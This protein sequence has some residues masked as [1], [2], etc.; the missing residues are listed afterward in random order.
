MIIVSRPGHYAVTVTANDCRGVDSVKVSY[1][2]IC[3]GIDQRLEDKVS[4]N[5]FPNPSNGIINLNMTG[6]GNMDVEFL[7]HT[8]GGQKVFQANRSNLNE[9]HEDKLDISNLADGIY[10]L[11]INTS[12]GSLVYRITI[13]R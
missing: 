5:I 3:V 8:T 6:F 4:V 7:V 12:E 9:T 10:L 13:N 2:A 11:N 1:S